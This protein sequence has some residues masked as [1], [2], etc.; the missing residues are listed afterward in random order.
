MKSLS[1]SSAHW[2]WI[3]TLTSGKKYSKASYILL[4]WA[5]GIRNEW[6]ARRGKAR[7]VPDRHGTAGMAGI[8]LAWVGMARRG[9]AG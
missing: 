7:Q 2:A 1:Q 8:G 4:Y 3:S 6:Q 9:L 5:R